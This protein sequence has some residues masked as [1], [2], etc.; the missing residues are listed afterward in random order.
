MK[1]PY[2]GAHIRVQVGNIYHHGI[3]IGNDEVVQFGSP[4]TLGVIPKDVRVIRSPIS[5]FLN[6]GFLEVRNFTKKEKKIKN[7]DE[8][9]I[10]NALSRLGEGNYDLL[11]NN[12][13]H[14]VNECIFNRKYS[15]QI[16]DIHKTIRNKLGLNK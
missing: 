4:F 15:T 3:F 16:D 2:P 10:K 12:C 5:E 14:F 8:D 7:S 1:D 9:I 13:E 6:D 11:K